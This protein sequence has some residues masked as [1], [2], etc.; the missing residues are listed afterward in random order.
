VAVTLL[1]SVI[2]PVNK[3]DVDE[4]DSKTNQ[5]ALMAFLGILSE[6]EQVRNAMVVS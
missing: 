1:D 5:E 2:P 6:I 4:A 3:T